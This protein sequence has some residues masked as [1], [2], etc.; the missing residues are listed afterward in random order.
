MCPHSN[1]LY[2]LNFIKNFVYVKVWIGASMQRLLSMDLGS[3]FSFPV[4]R[5]RLDKSVVV[6]L[7]NRGGVEK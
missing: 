5:L 7:R 2:G 3:P 1:Y 4:S 6:L